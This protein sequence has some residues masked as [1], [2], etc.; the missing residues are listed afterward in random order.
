MRSG[1]Q[2]PKPSSAGLGASAR[3]HKVHVD[4]HRPRRRRT[5][6]P[7]LPPLDPS[8]D[9]AAA[10]G[11]LAT[12]LLFCVF[13]A[14]QFCAASCDREPPRV[15][16]APYLLFA[17][18]LIPLEKFLKQSLLLVL[19]VGRRPCGH[20]SGTRRIDGSYWLLLGSI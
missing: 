19:V 2:A 10:A 8:A 17:P 15:Y 12:L 7:S 6:A 5:I 3:S 16:E 13:L 18:R 14:R 11:S 1:R 20:R 9:R 4:V